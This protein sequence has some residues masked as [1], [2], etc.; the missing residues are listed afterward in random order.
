[1]GEIGGH[2]FLANKVKRQQSTTAPGGPTFWWRAISGHFIS[3]PPAAPPP[4][5]RRRPLSRISPQANSARHCT[6][7]P[8]KPE[9]C[10]RAFF[11]LPDNTLSGS[12]AVEGGFLGSPR[13][14][15]WALTA[16]PPPPNQQMEGKKLFGVRLLT[17]SPGQSRYLRDRFNP[18][19][20]RENGDS[21]TALD[22][23]ANK[24]KR[25]PS[26]QLPAAPLFGG[27]RSP[28]TSSASRPPAPPPVSRRRPLSRISPQANSVRHCTLGPPKPELCQ[29]AFFRLPDKTL[30]RNPSVKDGFLGSPRS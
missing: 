11:Q 6:L 17:I 1:M 2:Y 20:P 21:K 19:H 28:G 29:R 18:T 25:Q 5:S 7:G 23:P 24:L 3:R 13:L 9:L 30:S 22:S 15:L 10:Q 27:G 4:V 12:R 16:A 8:P 14:S 26:T